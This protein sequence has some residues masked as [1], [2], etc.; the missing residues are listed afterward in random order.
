MISFLLVLLSFVLLFLRVLDC[1]ACCMLVCVYAM[2][3]H[4]IE[5]FSKQIKIEYISLVTAVEHIHKRIQGSYTY[6]YYY[7]CYCYY[8]SSGEKNTCTRDLWAK[9][10]DINSA[11]PLLLHNKL[12]FI[13]ITP[14]I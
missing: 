5:H 1:I 2:V 14:H 10:D 12:V 7:C 13:L 3:A 11:L 8:C 9:C 6:D 4:I